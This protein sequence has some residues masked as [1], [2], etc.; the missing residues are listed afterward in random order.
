M[1][2]RGSL[3]VVVALTWPACREHSATQTRNQPGGATT[4]ISSS[5][6]VRVESA[7]LV[8][9]STAPPAGVEV[10]EPEDDPGFAKQG[11]AKLRIDEAVDVA[12]AGAAAAIPEGVLLLLRNGSLAVAPWLVNPSPGRGRAETPIAAL[13]PEAQDQILRARGPGVLGRYVYYT[14]RHELIRR[15][16]PAGAPER[17]ALDA[18]PYA[19]VAV[20]ETKPEGFNA[21]AAYIA[22]AS[23]DSDTL[24]AKLWIDKMGTFTLT[25][26]GS[27]A[28][29]V[30]LASVDRALVAI[31]LESRTGMSPLHA[32]R[33]VMKGGRPD[34]SE[35]VVVWV[36]GGARSLTEVIA[37][38]DPPNLWAF[39]PLERDALHFGLARVEVGEHPEMQAHVA[40]RQYPNGLQ[41]AVV[42]SGHLC[43][44]P[45][46]IYAEPS[47]DQP[48]SP[49]E[50]RLSW[51]D[52]GRL[53][54]STLLAT[55]RAFVDLSYRGLDS[56]GLVVYAADGRTWA[57]RL[58]CARA[59]R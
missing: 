7:P 3:V 13:A 10:D 15:K 53:G 25:P 4:A 27:S 18:R 54:P 33:I 31:S 56:Y 55:S 40:W 37:L 19:R 44:R 39:I 1:L 16:I 23:D 5:A 38:S 51:I 52:Q 43:G 26:D 21:V 36:A 46:V 48:K 47:T 12:P 28:N 35:D 30:A 41:P 45:M 42:A 50:L 29:S 32:R 57:R 58:R 34:L 11:K 2:A 24:I 14:Q 59:T 20:P 49:Q 8:S 9:A 17:L 6:G 22:R